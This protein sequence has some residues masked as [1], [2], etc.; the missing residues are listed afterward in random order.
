MAK[1][2]AYRGTYYLWQYV[3]SIPAAIIFALL[4]LLPTIFHIWKICKTR[5]RFCIPFAI[6][7]VCTFLPT[8]S[9][10]PTISV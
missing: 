9:Y 1:L 8:H 5:A 6:G 3:P 4:F 10:L 2:E 7:G